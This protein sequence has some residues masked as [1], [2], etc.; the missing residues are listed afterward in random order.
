[1]RRRVPGSCAV[2]QT[3]SELSY[4]GR[5]W[6]TSAGGAIL[7]HFGFLRSARASSAVYG[8]QGAKCGKFAFSPLRVSS[9]AGP[10]ERVDCLGSSNRIDVKVNAS[11]RVINKSLNVFHH[12][13]VDRLV[14]DFQPVVEGLRLY[15]CTTTNCGTSDLTATTIH[16]KMTFLVLTSIGLKCSIT[17]CIGNHS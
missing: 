6:S 9:W 1:M 16:S 17:Y 11:M 14:L 7:P 15:S 8:R 12:L 2:N 5:V 13:G 4:D 3:L 10:L